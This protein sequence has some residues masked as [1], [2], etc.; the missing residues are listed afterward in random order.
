MLTQKLLDLAYKGEVLFSCIQ[1]IASGNPRFNGEY[2]LIRTLKNVIRTA[3]DAGA[4]KGDWTAEVLKCTS[5]RAS[6]ICIEPDPRNVNYV[7]DRFRRHSQIQIVEA[8]IS[9]KTGL[10]TFSI[11]EGDHSGVGCLTQSAEEASI[12]V[13]VVTLE[14]ICK[15]RGV[16]YFDLVKADIE[17]EEMAM[18]KGA[19]GLFR[20]R[21]IG[22]IQIEYNCTWLRTNRRMKE[23]FEFA[24]DYGYAVLAATPLG[25]AEYPAYG[26]GLEDYRMRNLILSSKEHLKILKPIRASG[27]ARV[28]AARAA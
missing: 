23:V 25:F 1:G 12:Q 27:R 2:R 26:E 11:G 8:A 6:V 20:T 21:S 7:R 13:A 18:L 19:E 14:S 5:Q 9:D 15:E 22:T 24:H 28:E 4:N 16:T 10:A 17:G 3:M